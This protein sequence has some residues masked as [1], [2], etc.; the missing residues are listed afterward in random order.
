[1]RWDSAVEV[2]IFVLD[3]KWALEH[4]TGDASSQTDVAVDAGGF[5]VRGSVFITGASL[6]CN[7]GGLL[8]I[9]HVP[10]QVLVDGL[11]QEQEKQ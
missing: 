3:G 1:M 6:R 5:L 11:S 8:A 2:M 9:S 10:K 7:D 4:D